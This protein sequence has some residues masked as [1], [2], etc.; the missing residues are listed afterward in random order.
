MDILISMCLIMLGVYTTTTIVLV[1]Y[2]WRIHKLYSSSIK[3]MDTVADTIA[4]EHNAMAER[5][6]SLQDVVN[7]HEFKLNGSSLSFI[8]K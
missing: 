1:L 2:C 4:K 3:K 8:K 5:L 7:S 6:L